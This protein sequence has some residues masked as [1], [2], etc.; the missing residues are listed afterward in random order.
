[1]SGPS[2]KSAGVRTRLCLPQDVRSGPRASVAAGQGTVQL[3]LP[4]ILWHTSLWG[5]IVAS[6]MPPP[7]SSPHHQ[8]AWAESRATCRE[9]GAQCGVSCHPG[10]FPRAAGQMPVAV[11]LGLFGGVGEDDLDAPEFPC[12][13]SG[14]PVSFAWK[15]LRRR[16]AVQARL[17]CGHNQGAW[18][19]AAQGLRELF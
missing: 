4:H 16:V 13:Q 5:S 19:P 15:A 1:M 12:L 6:L 2:T 9:L 8:A 17:L 3:S 11:S 14:S 10:T 18:M 7:P